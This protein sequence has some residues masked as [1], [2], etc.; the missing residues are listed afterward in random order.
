MGENTHAWV[1]VAKQKQS[2]LANQTND[3]IRRGG[4]ILTEEAKHRELEKPITNRSKLIRQ[5][6]KET[7][8]SDIT[9]TGLFD[10]KNLNLPYVDGRVALLGD[11]AHPQ[12]PMMG[13]GANMAIVDGYVVASRLA[14]AK[15]NNKIV[16]SILANYDCDVRR[17][18]INKVIIESRNHGTFVV[19]RNPFTCWMVKM[20]LKCMPQSLMMKEM[21]RGDNSNKKF[22]KAMDSVKM[23]SKSK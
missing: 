16:T 1:Y 10:R 18:G 23:A 8:A 3:L 2:P 21:V 15:N 20:V 7:P 6:I 9:R 19:S 17:K 22:V 14:A 4:S 11:A 13:Q 12:S 5:F